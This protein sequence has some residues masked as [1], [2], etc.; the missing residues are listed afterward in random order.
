MKEI[1][2]KDK[3]VITNDNFR[4]MVLIIYR[5]VANIPVILMGETGCGKTSL[6]RELNKLLND[7]KENLEFINIH[8][9]V[10]EDD[11]KER[12][13]IINEKAKNSKEVIWVFF[14]E[15]NTCNSFAL[16]TEIFINRSFEGEN[17]AENIRVIGACNPY[18]IRKKDTLKCGLSYTDDIDD[19]KKDY[20]YLVNMLP[21]S[22]MFYIFNF[23]S[24]NEEDEKKYIK[25]IISKQ[26]NSEEEESKNIT[27]DIISEC[28]KFFREKFDPSVVS[29]REISRFSRCLA[30][31]ID[32]YNKKNNYYQKMNDYYKSNNESENEKKIIIKN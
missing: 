11:L 22:L 3:Y 27:K 30:F 12:M 17:L 13:A 10:T 23:G 25:S 16:L 14:D 20:V 8:P 6:I 32:Y 18:R 5:I 15:L 29:L 28:H 31:F 19:N 2:D 26:F 9:G 4:K 24:I 21:Q 1:I 7:G